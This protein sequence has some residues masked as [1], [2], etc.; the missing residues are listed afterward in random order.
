MEPTFISDINDGLDKVTL[1]A[2]GP[3]Y[4]LCFTELGFLYSWGM[5]NFDDPDS[6]QR[7]PTMVQIV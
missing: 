5:L 4:S 1:I 6:I 7:L 2:C 3:H